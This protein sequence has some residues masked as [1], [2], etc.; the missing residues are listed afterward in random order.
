MRARAGRFGGRVH[1]SVPREGVAGAEA[2]FRHAR[3]L[4]GAAPIASALDERH[5]LIVAGDC[6]GSA[7]FRHG[8]RALDQYPCPVCVDWGTR[9][10]RPAHGA[11]QDAWHPAVGA[12][13][14]SL[15]HHRHRLGDYVRGVRRDP[16][17][18]VR[19]EV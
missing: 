15:L 19:K 13:G 17:R 8:F 3:E 4:I 11:T 14:H 12:A 5:S 7:E 6:V 10:R 9:N 16:Y 18:Y 2:W 1:F